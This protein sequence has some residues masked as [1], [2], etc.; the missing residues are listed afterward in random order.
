MNFRVSN[1]K[2]YVFTS[3]S[4]ELGYLSYGFVVNCCCGLCLSIH[5]R[6]LVESVEVV[7]SVA[8]EVIGKTDFNI[9]PP[10]KYVTFYNDVRVRF[11]IQSL[12][13][14]PKNG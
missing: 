4:P 7:S 9:L 1:Y 11:G 5:L 3:I 14:A 6:L 10:S 12:L 2:Y 13:N 8:Q